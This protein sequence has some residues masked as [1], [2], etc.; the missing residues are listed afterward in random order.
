M[1]K[2]AQG[3]KFQEARAQE[4]LSSLIGFHSFSTESNPHPQV[5]YV[6]IVATLCAGRMH[7]WQ[8]KSTHSATQQ[9]TQFGRRNEG[10]RERRSCPNKQEQGITVGEVLR[11]SPTSIKM[12][13]QAQREERA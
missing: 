4:P 2:E 3:S 7:P 8:V 9:T 11:L 12:I 1:I 10:I 5:I 13:L 6:P